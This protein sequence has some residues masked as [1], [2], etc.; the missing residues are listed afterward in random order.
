MSNATVE[1]GSTVRKA[2]VGS[3]AVVKSLCTVSNEGLSEDEVAYVD[4]G[5]IIEACSPKMSYSAM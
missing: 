3:N 4:E 5:T 2:I 1:A